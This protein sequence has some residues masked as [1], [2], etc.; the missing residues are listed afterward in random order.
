M[1]FRF[2]SLIYILA[3]EH[4]YMDLRKTRVYNSCKELVQSFVNELT[5]LKIT[6]ERELLMLLLF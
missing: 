6:P 1:E 3:R 2:N 5:R 4:G